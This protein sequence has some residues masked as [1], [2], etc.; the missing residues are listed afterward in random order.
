AQVEHAGQLQAR[1]VAKPAKQQHNAAAL[2]QS[3]H[4][5]LQLRPGVG[6][7]RRR[8]PDLYGDRWSAFGIDLGKRDAPALALLL[9]ERK[10]PAPV[11]QLNPGMAGEVIDSVEVGVGALLDGPLEVEVVVV[12]LQQR[13]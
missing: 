2:D 8:R 5:L 4:H 6:P 3:A 13:H 7:Y 9:R 11:A 1:A 10:L 12:S